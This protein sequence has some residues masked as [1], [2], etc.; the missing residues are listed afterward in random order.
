M[1]KWFLMILLTFGLLGVTMAQNVEASAKVQEE[2]I[3]VGK[4]FTLD[5]TLKAPYGSVVEWNGFVTD[6]LSEQIDI[7]KRGDLVRTADADSNIIVQ[8]QLTLMT[9]DT[10]Y[11]Q[12]PGL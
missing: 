9:F 12:I 8:Q 1:K 10:G 5:L 6:T 3:A 7:L 4:P 2:Q 11:I